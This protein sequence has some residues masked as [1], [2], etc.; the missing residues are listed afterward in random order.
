HSLVMLIL[1]LYLSFH[2]FFY[3]DLLPSFFYE[4]FLGELVPRLARF[5]IDSYNLSGSPFLLVVSPDT[6]RKY[7]AFYFGRTTKSPVVSVVRSM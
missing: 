4:S 2:Y 6:R 3:T 7:T 1:Q 5:A